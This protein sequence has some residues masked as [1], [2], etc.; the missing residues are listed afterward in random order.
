MSPS[1]ARS[2]SVKAA[3]TSTGPMNTPRRSMRRR[4]PGAQAEAG[5]Q[6]RERLLDPSRAA[7]RE[8]EEVRRQQEQEQVDDVAEVVPASPDVANAAS[9]SAPT[10]LMKPVENRP[11]RTASRVAAPAAGRV[12]RRRRGRARRR[13]ARAAPCRAR[14]PPSGASSGSSRSRSARSFENRPAAPGPSSE[15]ATST[16]PGGERDLAAAVVLGGRA[17]SPHVGDPRPGRERRDAQRD[18]GARQITASSSALAGWRRRDEARCARRAG[19]RGSSRS[20]GRP[21]AEGSLARRASA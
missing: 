10:A 8:V 1:I 15:Q 6:Q 14:T 18:A 17:R 13:S 9:A 4:R 3:P 2:R 16:A 11:A 19:A 12:G 20:R 7:G 5:E 21:D